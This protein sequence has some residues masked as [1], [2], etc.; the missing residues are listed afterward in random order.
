MEFVRLR[1]KGLRLV[2]S[3]CGLLYAVNEHLCLTLV[4]V[5]ANSGSERIGGGGRGKVGSVVSPAID[6]KYEWAVDGGWAA[7]GVVTDTCIGNG[8]RYVIDAAGARGWCAG[9]DPGG[10]VQVQ[11]RRQ[12]RCAPVKCPHLTGGGQR[13]GERHVLPCQ[14]VKHWVDGQATI[15]WGTRWRWG[16][17]YIEGD[18]CNGRRGPDYAKWKGAPSTAWA[19][20]AKLRAINAKGIRGSRCQRRILGRA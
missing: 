18:S 5:G 15:W 11:P 3:K 12:C 1:S 13:H 9:D 10:G 17:Y 7:G 20:N 2:C 8:S 14:R 4:K 19:T 16:R 6:D